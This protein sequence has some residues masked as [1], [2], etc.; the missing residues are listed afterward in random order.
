MCNQCLNQYELM[1]GKQSTRHAIYE[2]IYTVLAASH[3]ENLVEE[4]LR[5]QLTARLG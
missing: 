3:S 5:V 2:E 1:I 4:K